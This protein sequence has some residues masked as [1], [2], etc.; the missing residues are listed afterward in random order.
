MINS[1]TILL[2]VPAVSARGGITN[3]FEVLKGRFNL[4][5][6]YMLRGARTWP[7][8]KRFFKEILRVWKDFLEFRERIKKGDIELI[9]TST[10]LDLTSLLRD[11]LNIFYANKKHIKTIVFFRGWD[12]NLEDKIDKY[13]LWIFKFVFFRTDSFIV[14]SSDFKRKLEK[15]GYEKNIEL[16]TTIIDEY[17]IKDFSF[18]DHIQLREKRIAASSINILFLARVE[19]PKGIYET[20]ETFTILKKNNSNINLKLTIAGDGKEL[21]NVKTFIKENQI[22]NVS[23]LG[24]VKEK[25]KIK[26]LLDADIYFFPSYT[27]G[28][29]NSVLEAMAFGLPIV[30]R[31]VGAIPD[32]ISNENNGYHTNSKDPND[33]AEL[34]QKIIDSHTLRKKMAAN[35]QKLATERFTT[36][37]V[38]D[39]IENIYENTVNNPSDI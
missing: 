33:L 1:K 18:E 28:M 34:I 16:E 7:Y 35:N 32:I 38:L 37:V 10:S 6:E 2:L 25:S 15:W 5:V 3:Y 23:V 8:R 17:L 19:I 21:P 27:E 26:A 20:I 11:G 4:P 13:F 30:T 22:N 14:L 9:Q 29:P 24:F 31:S 39:R 12:K 36:S